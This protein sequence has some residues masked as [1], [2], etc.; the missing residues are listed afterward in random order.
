[1]NR[2]ALAT[3]LVAC[4]A[5]AASA[6]PLVDT[7]VDTTPGI[8]LGA[9]SYSYLGAGTG[10]GG[11]LGNG[12]ISFDSDNTNLGVRFNA[13]GTL[14]NLV[15]I[16]IDSRA[17]GFTD[18]EMDDQADGG[19]RA[20]TQLANATDD[21]FD[22][23]FRPD[24]GLIIGN[25]GTVLFE[26][27]AGNTPNHLNFL[28]FDG[29]T[30]L[31]RDYTIPLA[32]LGL[33]PGA[34]FKFLAAYTSDSGYLSNESIP[35]YAPLQN[36]GNPGFGDGQFG[37]TVGSPGLGNYNVFTTIPTPGAAALMGLAGLAG[38]RRRRA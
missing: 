20:L 37:G 5:G 22:A 11:T 19:R 7:R 6:R 9:N 31:P 27:T 29:G 38:L 14:D 34:S 32:T 8:N 17:G 16:F 10:F 21:A 25:F 2:I 23:D 30:N 28:A 36:N 12:S 24:F 3:A 13:A 18:A 4:A 1:M 15:A 26:L 35:A 33:A